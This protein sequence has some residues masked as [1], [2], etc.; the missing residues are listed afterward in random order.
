M[1]GSLDNVEHPIA[2]F[3]L[4]RA[5]FVSGIT[6]IDKDMT[7]PLEAVPDAGEHFGHAVA[8]LNIGS[9]DNGTDEEA[10]GVRQ[11]LALPAVDLLARVIAPWPSGFRDLDALGLESQRRA[12][13]AI[14]RVGS[15]RAL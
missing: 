10:L 11:D 13:I 6:A 4:R 15:I 1:V 9:V 2:D 14:T 3:G 7:Q 8:I 12:E 5:E